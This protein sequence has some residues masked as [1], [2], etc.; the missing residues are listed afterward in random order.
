MKLTTARLKKLIREELSK[1]VSEDITEMNMAGYERDRIS[2]QLVIDDYKED[3]VN[4]EIVKLPFKI[5]VDTTQ[6]YGAKAK[7]G[8]YDHPTTQKL[9]K[10]SLMAKGRLA[11]GTAYHY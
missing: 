1:V 8:D 11:D 10:Q 3:L 9:I 7:K 4:G 5:K 2:K 6:E